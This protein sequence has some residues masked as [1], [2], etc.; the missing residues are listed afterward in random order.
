M[1]AGQRVYWHGLFPR[2]DDQGTI[3]RTGTLRHEVRWDRTPDQITL[4]PVN[5]LQSVKAAPK[6]CAYCISYLADPGRHHEERRWK[7]NP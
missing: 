2:P 1:N 4:T 7:L 5:A 6:C 3:V